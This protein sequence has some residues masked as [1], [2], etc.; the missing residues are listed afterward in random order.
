MRRRTE[1]A[2]S[3]ETNQKY[4]YEEKVKKCLSGQTYGKIKTAL[5]LN[6]YDLSFYP[7]GDLKETV[8]LICKAD[9]RRL[10]VTKTVDELL[11]NLEEIKGNIPE[12]PT[13][14]KEV[15][16]MVGLATGGALGIV[17]QAGSQAERS[18][19]SITR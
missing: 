5:F 15:G 4:L 9:D 19:R 7:K 14:T 17:K 16:V 6:Q 1:E 11:K 12:F 10:E 18:R 2:T 3:Q 8:T 13:C